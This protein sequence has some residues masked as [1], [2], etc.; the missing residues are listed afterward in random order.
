MA[1]LAAEVRCSEGLVFRVKRSMREH[2]RCHTTR[3][4]CRLP[5]RKL[6]WPALAMAIKSGL[7][8]PVAEG[9]VVGPAWSLPAV[10]F[11]AREGF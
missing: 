5:I 11:E 4:L 1:Q 7:A 6:R 2:A 9:G 10:Q 8:R 3:R